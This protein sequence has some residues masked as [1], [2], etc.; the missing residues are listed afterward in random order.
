MEKIE[1]E[2]GKIYFI[3]FGSSTQLVARYR[4]DDVCN[5]IFYDQ[6]GRASCRERV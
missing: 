1:M 2:Q 5:Y 3:S 4:S 6:I